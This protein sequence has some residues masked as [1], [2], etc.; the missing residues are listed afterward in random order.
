MI[1]E[2][3]TQL[4]SSLAFLRHVG[5]LP[6]VLH[7]LGES[8]APALA[9]AGLEEER[10]DGIPTIT[11]E[12]MA[13]RRRLI[14]E[15]NQRLV[16][17]LE[18]QETR[19]RPIL[20]GVFEASYR[21]EARHGLVGTIDG[22]FDEPIRAA[23]DNGSLPIVAAVGESTSGQTLAIDADEAMRGL[24]RLIE[25]FKIIYLT[26]DEGLLDSDGRYIPAVNL[27]T[28]DEAL[29]TAGGE[30]LKQIAMLLEELPPTSSVSVTAPAHLTRELFTH[31]GAGTLVR[32]GERFEIQAS[33]APEDHQGIKE[34]LE[35]CFGRTLVA[36]YFD[37]LPVRELVWSSSRRAAAIML[38]GRDDI[39]Y[40]DKFA[41]TPAAQGEGLG[42]ALWR[43]LRGRYPQLY[44]RSRLDNPIND[45]Y[46]RQ[47]DASVRSGRWRVFAYGVPLEQLAACCEDAAARPGCWED[48]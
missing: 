24:V 37:G 45:W 38:S 27:A 20:S 3:L 30:P 32:L 33:I 36:S 17:T 23:I 42:T 39:A 43:E 22:V 26:V 31:R 8:L 9:A 7:T 47:A 46:H 4:V 6:I 34:L 19:A 14:Q 15:H 10:H 44:W 41:V 21:D 16:D 11:P 1:D 12:V 28:A 40:M 25:P 18:Q 29:L 13:V 48:A 2:Q 5:L 35:Q